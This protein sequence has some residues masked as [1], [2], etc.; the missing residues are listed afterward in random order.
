MPDAERT[1]ATRRPSTSKPITSSTMNDRRGPGS[2]TASPRGM[3]GVQ[4]AA[5]RGQ[6]RGAEVVAPDVP[7]PVRD[8]VRLEPDDA[9]PQR[10]LLGAVALKR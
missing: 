3:R 1:E 9:H 5:A 4:P 8:V 7:E 10:Q 6:D 2:T